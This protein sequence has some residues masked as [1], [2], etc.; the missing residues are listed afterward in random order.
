M[1]LKPIVLLI[2]QMKYCIEVEPDELLIDVLRD[3]L[4]LT[5]TKKGCGTGDC[6][7]CTVI[8]AG[9]PVNSCLVLAAAADGKPILTIEGM[10][11][12][13]KLHPIQ[14]SFLDH[15]AL[16]CGYCTPGL[17]LSVKALLDEKPHPTDDE[18]RL[19]ISGNL[20]RCTGYQKI[21]EAVK[22]VAETYG[23]GF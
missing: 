1:M 22:A 14:Q 15:H 3:R 17:V 12:D 19:G 10:Q 20:C 13:G 9:R 21:I 2:N 7:A 11:R 23:G 16:Q 8:L 6:G 4:G 5:G 18:I